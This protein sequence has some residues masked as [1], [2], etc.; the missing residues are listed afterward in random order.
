MCWYWFYSHIWYVHV[1]EICAKEWLIY[2]FTGCWKF[3][4]T[5]NI[6]SSVLLLIDWRGEF[7]NLQKWCTTKNFWDHWYLTWTGMTSVICLPFIV[8]MVR[9][10]PHFMITSMFSVLKYHTHCVRWKCWE[11]HV[12]SCHLFILPLF[13]NLRRFGKSRC[14]AFVMHLDIRYV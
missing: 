14:I 3:Y 1:T 13:Q 7:E 10:C 4:Q 12:L 5:S 6:L 11:K 8:Q 2:W 9:Y